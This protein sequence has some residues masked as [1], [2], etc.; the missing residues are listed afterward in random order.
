MKKCL[1]V[2]LVT[3]LAFGCSKSPQDKIFKLH[4]DGLQQID[5]YDFDAALAT[6]EKIGEIDP[7]TPLGYYG[8]GLVLE[9]QLQYYDALHVY[10]SIT[11]SAPSFAPAFAGAWRMFT[12]LEQFDDAAQAAVEYSR[13]L[14]DDAAARLIVAKALM[15]ITQC[16]RARQE[17]NM[18]VELGADPAVGNLAIARAYRLEHKA[19]SA[20]AALEIAL[21]TSGKSPEYYA[22]AAAYFEAAGLIDSALS[23]G[24]ASVES[25]GNDFELMM[26]HFYRALRHNYFFDARQVIYK[27]KAN[28]APELVIAGMEMFYHLA[29]KNETDARHACDDFARISSLSMSALVYDMVVRAKTQDLLTA[30][31][32]IGAIVHTMRTGNY[33]R[34]FQDVMKYLLAV[35][36]ADY[37]ADLACLPKLDA[38]A[39]AFS[40]RKEVKLRTAYI[41]HVTGQFEKFEELMAL[42]STYHSTQ[43]DWLTGMADIYADLSIR[44]YEEAEQYYRLALKHDKWYRQAFENEVNMYRRLNQPVK[45]LE[46]FN[47]Y[48]HFEQQYPE[49]S[50]LRAMCLVENGAVQEGGDL[51]EHS[52]AHVRGDLTI[53]TEITSLLDKKDKP[54]E[55]AKL[56]RLLPQ[57]NADNADALVLAADFVSEQGSFE[58]ALSFAEQAL[59][60]ES[61]YVAASVQKAWA[62]YGLGKRSEA[63]EIFERNLVEAHFNVDNNYYFSRILATEQID[64][65]RAAN[66]A[67]RAVFDSSHD[68]KVWMNL[69]YVY[70]QIGRYDL[71]RGEALK[72][73]RSHKD[74]PEPFFR[75]GM[76]MYMEGKEEA[77]ENLQKAIELGLK[78]EDLELA[79]QTLEKL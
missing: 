45:A 30:S 51:F 72:A 22:E 65:D 78:G 26:K 76:A 11:N 60:I 18:A 37:F 13:L 77:E 73:S 49:I 59:S 6:F 47:T 7:T 10:L 63:F 69:C 12:H 62:L 50:L 16:A 24:R 15:N 9:R 35:M 64:L 14:P 75:M 28:G 32:N 55:V 71:S 1:L 20:K 2:G 38:V 41:L 57:I 66:L 48:P 17:L 46:L 19:D 31:Q 21:S 58:S 27:L 56:Y 23:M 29:K 53:F 79:R 4:Q 33:D 34:E 40:N 3:V 43:P 61:D 42:L 52:F 70:F 25:A 44:R 5:K 8:S 54:E 39:G 74:E 67:R 36:Y 68:L